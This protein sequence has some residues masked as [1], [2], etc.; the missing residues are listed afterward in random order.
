MRTLLASNPAIPMRYGGGLFLC[1]VGAAIALGAVLGG[2]AMAPLLIAGFVLGAI[3]IF[4]VGPGVGRRYGR[5]T[6]RQVLLMIVAIMF[7][8]AALGLL[9]WS[10]SSGALPGDAQFVWTAV[11]VIVAAHFLLM[12]W[13]FGAWI[14]HLGVAILLWAAFAVTQHLELGAI[15]LGDGLLKLGFGAIMAAPLFLQPK[16]GAN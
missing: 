2:D 11:V 4:L 1:C 9:S 15:L 7:Q 14:F 12:T 8:V 10:T 13:S 5:P 3:A 6:R 16:S